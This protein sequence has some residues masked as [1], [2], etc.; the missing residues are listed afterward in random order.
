MVIIYLF[1]FY[2]STY[3]SCT[4]AS[5]EKTW[6]SD[7]NRLSNESLGGI[8]PMH[9]QLPLNVQCLFISFNQ[10]GV[11]PES[12]KY[13]FFCLFSFSTCRL[14]GFINHNGQIFVSLFSSHPSPTRLTLQL[15]TITQSMIQ[16]LFISSLVVISP[17]SFSFKN[18]K[19]DYT[20]Y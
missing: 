16:V 1:F 9:H 15:L 13:F 4:L 12:D 19:Y 17:P 5:S 6:R 18:V 8:R 2:S 7:F 14:F 11:I 10:N 3:N 20:N